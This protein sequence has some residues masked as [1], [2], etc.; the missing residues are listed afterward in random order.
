M[1][2]RFKIQPLLFLCLFLS[3]PNFAAAQGGTLKNGQV[4]TGSLSSA[5]QVD[6]WGTVYAVANSYICATLVNTSGDPLFTPSFTI[7]PPPTISYGASSQVALPV[8]KLCYFETVSGY[9]SLTVQNAYPFD[10]YTFAGTY[11]LQVATSLPP[12]AGVGAGGSMTNG[13]V[14]NAS[15]LN[16]YTD[17][18]TFYATAGDKAKFSI[19]SSAVSN[20]FFN[21]GPL[22][23]Q[24]DGTSVTLRVL[25][26]TLPSRAHMFCLQGIASPGHNLD[27]TVIHSRSRAFLDLQPVPPVKLVPPKPT[28]AFVRPVAGAELLR[29]IPSIWR[30]AAC[31]KRSPTTRQLA[32]TLSLLSVITTACPNSTASFPR[33]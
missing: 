29:A 27:H 28:A 5:T 19:S 13:V 8:G 30:P 10:A 16:G 33:C 17:I 1:T 12:F 23:F 6:N 25:T 20:R 11:S 9:Y 2:I 24:P 26:A 18:W 4:E 15:N 21:P 3:L 31:M 32:R 7:T 14:Y 22:I